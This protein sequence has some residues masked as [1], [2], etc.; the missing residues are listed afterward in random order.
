MTPPE[1]SRLPRR[2]VLLYGL[3]QSGEGIT[4]HS[5]TS[6][7]LFYYTSVLGL[8]GTLAGTALMIGLV[9]DAITD[10]LAAV[11][12]DR[13]RS[14]FGRRHPYL[15]ASALPLGLCLALAFL[16]QTDFAV[17]RGFDA[18]PFLFVWLLVSVVLTRSA[19]TLFHVPHM[20]LGAELSDDFD[21]RT[22]VVTARS[23]LSV[24]GSA[25]AVTIYFTL[26]AVLADDSGRDPR[27]NPAPYAIYGVVAGVLITLA[28]L[29][30]TFGTRDRIARLL[31]PS[32]T[33]AGL[34]VLGVMLRD[35]REALRIRS[36]RSLFFG[37]TVCFLSFGFTNALGAHAALYFWHVSLE[38]QGSF[39]IAILTGMLAGMPFW[40]RFSERHDK[41][42]TFLTGLGWFVAFTALPPL[43]KVAGLFP[44]EGSALYVPTFLA[45]GFGLAFAIAAAMVVVGSMMADITDEDEVLHRQRREGIFFGAL[46]FA[47]KAASGLGTVIAGIVYDLS[48]L[49]RGLD[50]A[51]APP[52]TATVIGLC[53]G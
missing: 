21:E 25:T 43:A 35:T 38:V 24:V 3:G 13:T 48:G 19:L 5:L 53:M 15:L 32:E 40:K 26:V 52:H 16:P 30:S 12:S 6:V 47:G 2:T 44:A 9:F 42:P 23:L 34:G 37:F 14:R 33:F 50:P 11:L 28:V 10:P 18:Q 49:Y 17:A 31:P 4:N 20:A 27:L 45:M 41:R 51:A 46:S 36:F 22:R 29:A 39:G 1:P 8:S 7:L